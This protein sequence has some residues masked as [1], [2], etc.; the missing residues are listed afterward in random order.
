MF[1]TIERDVGPIEVAVFNIGANVRF[2]ITVT[3]S[4][5]FRKVWEMACYG[6]FLTGREAAKRTLTRGRGTIIYTGATASALGGDGFAAFASAKQGLR[7]LAQSMAHELGPQGIHV[8]HVSRVRPGP[9]NWTYVPGWS[10]SEGPCGQVSR[11]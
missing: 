6:G 11:L 1:D 4:R 10:R 8:A 2:P 9:R 7:A 3:T 5:V